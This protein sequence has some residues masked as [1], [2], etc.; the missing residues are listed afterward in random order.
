MQCKD[1]C[2][3]ASILLYAILCAKKIQEVLSCFLQT[4]HSLPP[5]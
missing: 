2:L 4:L 1:L 3:L 5:S